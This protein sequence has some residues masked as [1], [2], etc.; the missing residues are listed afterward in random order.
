MPSFLPRP[1][2]PFLKLDL[3]PVIR[4]GLVAALLGLPA[5]HRANRSQPTAKSHE[6]TRAS[7]PAASATL[8]V[9][10]TFAVDAVSTRD[11]EAFWYDVPA[12]SLPQRRAWA[13]ELTAASDSLPLDSYVRVRRLDGGL[14]DKPVVVR[15][16][17]TGIHNKGGLLDLNREAAEALDMIKIGRVKVRVET[18]ALK[19]ATTDKPVDKKDHP[20][21]P[22]ASELNGKPAAGPQAEKDAANAKTGG[23]SAP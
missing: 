10:P 11:G 7:T 16:T 21:A 15:I 6:E 19:N 13:G 3:P 17:D 8:P 22:K 23:Q 2:S 5:C 14:A 18:L 1:G 4:C 20:T 12:Q 9:L